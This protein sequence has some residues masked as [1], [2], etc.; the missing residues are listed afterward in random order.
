M[1][2]VPADVLVERLRGRENAKRLV[3]SPFMCNRM[4]QASTYDTGFWCGVVKISS[5]SELPGP[6]L[7]SSCACPAGLK[8]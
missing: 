4:F 6:V 1:N 8:K 5:K 7:Y 3:A 2:P